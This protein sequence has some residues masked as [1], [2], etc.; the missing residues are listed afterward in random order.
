MM[1]TISV[2]SLTVI[3]LLVAAVNLSAQN[4]GIGNTNPQSKLHVTGRVLADS[5]SIGANTANAKLDINGT[6]KITDG[7]QGIGKVLKSDTT[8]K[9]SWGKVAITD[10][11]DSLPA[12]DFSCLSVAGSLAT[13]FYS[14]AVTVSGNYAYVANH[15]NIQAV[16]ISNP[17]ALAVVGTVTTGYTPASIALSGSYAYVVNYANNILH[18]VNISNPSIM[19]VTGSVFVGSRPWSVAVSGNYAYIVNTNSHNM[20][21]I[22]ISNPAAPV[23]TGVVAT[24]TSP[25]GVAISGNYAYVVNSN[26]HNMQVFDLSNPQ[27]PSVV[28]TVGTGTNPV[29]VAISGNYAYVV[30]STANTLMVINI[31]NPAAPVVAG[32]VAT[33][34]S[35]GSVTVSGN[36]AYVANNAS[37]TLMV[38]NISN[39]AAPVVAGTV[40]TGISPNSVAISGNYAY[41][42]NTSNI[43][44][45]QSFNL[46]CIN[47]ISFDAADGQVFST[48][49]L[50]QK[51][52][53][54]IYTANT[55]N[56]GIGTGMPAYK[57]DVA[58]KVRITDTSLLNSA[59]IITGN[60]GIGTGTPA[61]KL[62]VA[63]KARIT[64]TAFV[65]KLNV[66]GN[67]QLGGTINQETIQS[68]SLQNGWINH[69]GGFTD[70]GFWKDKEGVVHIQ[71]LIKNGT[72]AQST[73]LFTLPAG[74]RPAARQIFTVMNN[75][76]SVRIDVL[77]TGEVTIANTISSNLWLNLTGIYFRVN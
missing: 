27:V 1:N 34:N 64:D 9:A 56:V 41:V 39:P 25:R 47:G 32:T 69:G 65:G 48:P 17:A 71:G 61:Y 63:G 2:K 58:G 23:V 5:L 29:S 68:P 59:L 37:N 43:N 52:G 18:V 33:G 44:N 7:T 42:A 54:S 49:L 74:Y 66:A 38:I 16:N 45:L 19:T 70:A 55:I 15:D 36:Y 76:L 35:P 73:I 28:G 50:W 75:N 20:Y 3:I 62:D 22:D 6:V 46:R 31:S 57:L 60:T 30:N 40:A 51:S 26:S 21:V 4:V 13:A 53:S 77:A 8:G 24:G 67:I 14:L 12:P 10:I 11:F 72:T